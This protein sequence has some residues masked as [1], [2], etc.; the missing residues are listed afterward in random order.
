VEA[1]EG[2]A[3]G[4]REALVVDQDRGGD[5]RSRETAAAGLVGTGD[6]AALQPAVEGEE[7]AAAGEAAA[8]RDPGLR[9]R[10]CRRGLGASR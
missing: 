7:A 4:E 1:A 5:Q 2:A 3:V 6:E 10:G 8:V 9:L